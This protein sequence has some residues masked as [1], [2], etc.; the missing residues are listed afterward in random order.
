[1]DDSCGKRRRRRCDCVPF[2]TPG[3]PTRMTRA[4][5]R[6]RIICECMCDGGCADESS[7]QIGK[8]EGKCRRKDGR[9][10]GRRVPIVGSK[11]WR[12]SGV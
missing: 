9:E 4:A 8:Q 2:P 10:S 12:G 5:V 6:K 3:A 7:V 1:M 11:R